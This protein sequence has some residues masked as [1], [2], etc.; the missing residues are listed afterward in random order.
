ME[1]V[2]KTNWSKM[3]VSSVLLFLVVLS[4]ISLAQEPPAEQPP[5]NVEGK[6]T[7]YAK[8]V[9]NGGSSTKYVEIKQNGNQLTGHFK[10]PHQSGGIEGTI[11]EHHIVFRTKTREVLTFRGRVE[12]NKMS[13]EYGI[14][15]EHGAWEAVRSD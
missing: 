6:W 14:H 7:I 12:G 11:N 8:N 4:S 1:N 9:N 5:D 2:M 10:G 3:L 15:G 13:G